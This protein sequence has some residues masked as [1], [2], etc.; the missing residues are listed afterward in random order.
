LENRSIEFG[1]DVTRE[2]G[3]VS[4]VRTTTTIGSLVELAKPGLSSLVVFTT[5][6]GYAVAGGLY[7]PLARTLLLI[8]GTAFSAAG[9]NAMNQ[10]VEFPFDALMMRTRLRPVACGVMTQKQA[11]IAAITMLSLGV[12][13]LG[14]SINSL[15]AFLSLLTAVL[16]ICVY[17]P[18]KQVTPF[19]TISGAITGAIPPM[20]GVAA[21]TGYLTLTAWILFAILFVWQIPH[22]IALSFIY[23]E[24]YENAGFKTLMQTDTTGIFPAGVSLIHTLALIPLS[25]SLSLA[26][27]A[28]VTFAIA[29]VVFGIVHLT[30]AVVFF[31]K[32]VYKNARILFFAGVTYLTLL[33][34]ALIVDSL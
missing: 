25:L 30:A 29:A 22:F 21:A 18:L 7:Q 24:D 4:N 12:V 11:L 3:C 17:T 14:I 27:S 1:S 16:Y 13:M 31:N 8:V 23:R 10:A 15:T 26:G 5:I 34:C 6:A 2:D 9:A 19:A 32:R 28:S 20:M 33:L